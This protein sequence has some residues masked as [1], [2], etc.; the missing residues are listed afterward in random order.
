MQGTSRLEIVKDVVD[1]CLGRYLEEPIRH[2]Y[3]LKIASRVPA[4][5]IP[6]KSASVA[7]S[8]LRPKTAALCFD[9][10]WTFESDL[11]KFSDLA[12]FAGSPFEIKILTHLYV[13]AIVKEHYRNH[14]DFDGMMTQVWW[15]RAED[16][17]LH[18]DEDE[19]VTTDQ[20]MAALGDF[21]DTVLGKPKEPLVLS[22]QRRL[23]QVLS[24]ECGIEAP[25]VYSSIE[26]QTADYGRGDRAAVIAA[27]SDLNIVDENTLSWDQVIEFR[28]DRLSQKSY[29][30][31]VRWLDLE[32]VGRPI[33]AIEDEI[34]KRL[35]DYEWALKKHGITLVLGALTTILDWKT[36][37]TA[38]TSAAF[39]AFTAG[40]FAAA[41]SAIGTAAV[42]CAIS[43]TN[44]MIDREDLKMKNAEIAF[45]HQ[46]KKLAKGRHQDYNEYRP[47]SSVDRG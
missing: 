14:P 10:I 8:F 13:H 44:A 34:E 40:K 1:H 6:K 12:L 43:I 32:M 15:G 22:L 30:R 36:L 23:R 47:H 9:R 41:L 24:L 26:E 39:A 16:V 27:L 42:R 3:A 4:K 37:L 33:P 25:V 21:L 46:V 11:P 2:Q 20:S 19:P 31:L 38:S 29:R 28:K 18:V 17:L 35:E 5:T 45:V 7:I